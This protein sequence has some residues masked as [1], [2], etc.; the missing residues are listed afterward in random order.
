MALSIQCKR[1]EIVADSIIQAQPYAVVSD[2]QARAQYAYRV[3]R[4][5]PRIG[6]G[7]IVAPEIGAPNM[8]AS[9]V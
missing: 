2:Q 7:R 6:L 5:S 4:S 1:P 9:V 8:L 3:T